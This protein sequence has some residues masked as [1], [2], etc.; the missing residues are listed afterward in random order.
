L[1][2]RRKSARRAGGQNLEVLMCRAL[3]VLVNVVVVTSV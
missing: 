3:D 1:R 2:G